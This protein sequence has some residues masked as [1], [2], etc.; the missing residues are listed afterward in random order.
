MRRNRTPFLLK[1]VQFVYPK[2]EKVFPGIAHRFFVTIFFSPLNYKVP[3]K[4]KHFEA[5]AQKFTIRAAGKKIQCYAW[6]TGPVILLVHGWAGR[7]TQFRKIIDGLV[8]ADFKVVGFDGP[9]HG[10]SEG[11]STNIQEFEET[12]REIYKKA[13][14]P[15]GI[16]AHSFGGG[17][18]LYAAM[19]G[20]TVKKLVNIATPTIGDDIIQTY[21]KTIRGS[22][23]TAAYFKKYIFNKYGKP[24]EEFTGLHFIRHLKQD[25]KL[26]LVH[27][28]SDPEVSIHHARE[29]I[30]LYPRA[31]LFKTKG[32]GHTRIL[33][34]ER[35][36]ERCVTFMK[37]ERL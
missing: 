10:N 31:S 23:E 19:N 6:G 12:L 2:L 5:S 3:E 33:R 1:L 8:N 24:F 27:D 14:M 17:A 18:V 11:R 7:A 21:L 13:G 28:E 29:L 36:I 30:K 22:R 9:A 32:L 35:V 20:L 26:L 34:D 15:E 37:A 4:E 25:V 16:I